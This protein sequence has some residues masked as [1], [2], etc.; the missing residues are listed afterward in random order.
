MSSATFTDWIL[1]KPVITEYLAVTKSN[2]NIA[3]NTIDH[4]LVHCTAE[5]LQQERYKLKLYPFLCQNVVP[6]QLPNL[7]SLGMD[8]NEMFNQVCIQGK[9]ELFTPLVELG[10]VPSVE[11]FGLTSSIPI[12]NHLICDVILD[13]TNEIIVFGR[14]VMEIWVEKSGKLPLYAIEFGFKGNQN[15]LERAVSFGD[16]QL[17][18]ALLEQGVQVSEKI[19]HLASI[20][21]NYAL[22]SNVMR[23]S[24]FHQLG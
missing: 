7:V 11:H 1:K 6:H 3:E 23:Y 19:Q 10:A 20:S 9:D 22:Y 2:R 17:V 13:T 5:I 4:H 15:C 24:L 21:G 8:V 16:E 18:N 14:N 12:F